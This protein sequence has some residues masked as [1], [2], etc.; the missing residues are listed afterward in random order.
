M[1]VA[2]GVMNDAARQCDA[3]TGAYAGHQEG[4]PVTREMHVQVQPAQQQ[5]QREQ[6]PGQPIHSN[7]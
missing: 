2:E 7:R 4:E 5:D 1:L 6:Q 3:D